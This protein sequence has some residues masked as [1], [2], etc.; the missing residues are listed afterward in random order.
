MVN[1]KYTLKGDESLHVKRISLNHMQ[2]LLESDDVYGACEL[3]SLSA[4]NYTHEVAPAV[5]G[6]GAPQS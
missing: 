6:V 1:T 4:D 2:A 5:F 3:H